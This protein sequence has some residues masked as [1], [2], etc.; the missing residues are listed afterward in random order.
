[1]SKADVGMASFNNRT[2]LGHCLWR[3]FGPVRKGAVGI[4]I[5]GQ[6]FAAEFRQPTRNKS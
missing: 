2:E 6:D 5:D 3:W 4:I 1:M